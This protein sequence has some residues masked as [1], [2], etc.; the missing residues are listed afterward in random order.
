MTKIP[1]TYAEEWARPK[2]TKLYL[3]PPL[4]SRMM[5]MWPDFKLINSEIKQH[6][7]AGAKAHGFIVLQGESDEG[8]PWRDT[9][10]RMRDDGIP[11]H[12]MEY[13]S[14][15]GCTLSMESF[16]SRDREPVAYCR[17][18]VRNPHPWPVQGSLSVM[19]RS[20]NELYMM[21]INAD[22]YCSY[23]PNDRQWDMLASN[24]RRDGNRLTDGEGHMTFKHTAAMRSEW[25]DAIRSPTFRHNR[26]LR[27]TYRL[28]GEEEASVDIAFS[29]AA[30]PDFSYEEEMRRTVEAWRHD[31]G[32]IRTY[33]DTA[34]AAPMYRTMF[35]HLVSQLLQ[36]IAVC[37]DTGHIIPRQGGIQRV[38]WPWEASEFLVALDRIGLHDYT[39]KVYDALHRHFQTKEGE[40]RGRIRATGPDWAG[41]TP[42]IVWSLSQRLKWMNDEPEFHRYRPML[43]ECYEWMERMRAK[44]RD[45]R[46][47]IVAGLFPPMSSSD[48]AGDHQ[49]WC[50]TDGNNVM[51][52]KEM[53]ELFARFGDPE[54][55]NIE[56]SYSDYKQVMD[57]VLR[58]FAEGREDEEELA[59]PNPLGKPW[60]DPPLWPYF[61]DGPAYLI[62]AGVLQPGS[63]PFE[64]VE[65]YF[66]NRGWMSNGLNGLMTC[67][68]IEWLPTDRWAGHTWYTT[69]A[70]LLW[71][72][73]WLESGQFGKAEETFLALIRYSMSEE[74]YM[75]ER[76]A[77]NDPSFVPWQ[78][79]ASGNGR[80]LM[81]MIDYFAALRSRTAEA[82][83]TLTAGDETDAD[84][85]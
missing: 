84:R 60:T 27:L 19:P 35:L 78:P 18:T 32:R 66:R 55:S 30:V 82:S 73:G 49:S 54:A 13:G 10:F 69:S 26:L 44:T 71:F 51:A 59:L 36:M 28:S 5:T 52:L 81:M 50:F 39:D 21:G 11:V 70:D 74:Y 22:G 2:T 3:H 56:S 41:H 23:D 38:T 64:Q 57:N 79:N 65:A 80:F 6:T 47:G 76:Y 29:R 46:D 75:Q 68:L 83:P 61:T 16:C 85:R 72:Y 63:R 14:G 77:D 45:S 33:P 8:I 15:N 1:E 34:G 53:Y 43:L 7:V 31:L 12:R 42:G 37:E 40:Q 17:L 25:I 20:G 24:W 58:G 9:T 4:A 62:R 67:S 48:F